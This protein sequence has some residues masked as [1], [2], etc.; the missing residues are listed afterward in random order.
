MIPCGNCFS[1]ATGPFAH[2]QSSPSSKREL[3]E[4][5]RMRSCVKIRE[6]S[7]LYDLPFPSKRIYRFEACFFCQ[8]RPRGKKPS[9]LNAWARRETSKMSDPRQAYRI[10][11]VQNQSMDPKE[12]PEQFQ[13]TRKKTTSFPPSPTSFFRSREVLL[14]LQPC[15]R[16][17]LTRD[18]LS[19]A[20]LLPRR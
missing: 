11:T 14:S 10:Q 19:P 3:Q 5:R 15:H 1:I 6:H 18:K 8:R 17:S 16:S 7:L 12:A 13:K 20:C 9:S 4:Q 2:Q